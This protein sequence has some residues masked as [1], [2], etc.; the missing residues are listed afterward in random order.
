MVGTREK[1]QWIFFTGV[2]DRISH[3]MRV[4]I[5]GTEQS[6]YSSVDT[7]ST[8]NVNANDLWIGA[9]GESLAGHS[10]FRGALDDIRLYRRALT[11]EEILAL[12]QQPQDSLPHVTVSHVH[13]FGNVVVGQSAAQVMR[14]SNSGLAPLIVSHIVSS[15]GKFHTSDSAL[16]VAGTV[17]G[18]VTITYSPNSIGLDTGRISFSTNDPAFPLVNLPVSGTGFVPGR[19][20]V[21]LSI[22]DIPADQGHQVRIIW[23]RS[24]F[25]ATND[26]LHA[27]FYDVWRRV[28]SGQAAW[29]FITSVPA[30]RLE[31]YGLVAPTL[32]D[33]TG[34][35][36]IHWS[37]FRVSTRFQ[38]QVD[39]AFS[40]PDSGY[41]TDDLIPASVAG[42][43]SGETPGL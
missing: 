29:D 41:S 24:K 43:G 12:Y 7:Y 37:I 2:I 40:L 33:S 13:D 38:E 26:S 4:Y 36:K 14:I 31:K 23:F 11:Q 39:P 20:P 10:S 9:G 16:T 30:S 15:S 3:A 6:L 28:G 19:A 18:N 42:S 1:Q 8:F 35:G 17:T 22:L 27:L 5:N 34:A 25:D 32:E 21:I